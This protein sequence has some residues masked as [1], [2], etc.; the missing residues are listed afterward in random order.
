MTTPKL[1]VLISGNGSNLQAIIDH[2]DSGNL[3]ASIAVVI[4]NQPDT[5][6]LQR[7]R[8]HHIPNQT[9]WAKPSESPKQYDQRLAK[10]IDLYQVDAVILAGFMRILGVDF[11]NDYWGKILN[12]HPAL[13][14][15]HKGLN[16]HQRVLD[17]GDRQHGA[18]IHF[19]TH[20]LDDGPVIMQAIIDVRPT[21]TSSTLRER[22]LQQEHQLY[23]AA[24]KLYLAKRIILRERQVWFDGRILQQPLVLGDDRCC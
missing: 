10:T 16:T 8:A 3:Q 20:E 1:A 19:V 9:I 13:L 11:V 4:S 5:Y 2:I 15:K 6:G 21:D 14:P 22:V 24:L 23:S 17:T 7:A 18:S 12:I